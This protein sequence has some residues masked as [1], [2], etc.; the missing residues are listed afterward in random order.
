M[1]DKCL[2]IAIF[3]II[4]NLFLAPLNSELAKIFGYITIITACAYPIIRAFNGRIVKIHVH[5]VCL[6]VLLLISVL[7]SAGSYEAKNTETYIIS[8]ISFIAFYWSISFKPNKESSLDL[9]FF[10]KANIVLCFIYIFHAFGPF[11]EKY[12]VIDSW[13][14]QVFN[15][16]LGNPNA[17]AGY[18]MFS[19]TMLL[20]QL[21]NDVNRLHKIVLAILMGIMVYILF[22]LQSRAV[23]LC[24]IGAILI[25]LIGKERRAMNVLNLVIV[26]APLGMLIVLPALD[27]AGVDFQLL[28][29]Q[30][31]TGRTDVYQKNLDIVLSNPRV[32]IVG[33]FFEFYFQNLHNSSLAIIATLGLS[34]Y[35]IYSVFWYKQIRKIDKEKKDRTQMVA[36]ICLIAYILHSSAET[37]F[38]VGTIPYSVF[39][40]LIVLIAKGEIRNRTTDI[41]D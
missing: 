5:V 26:L 38:M 36:F 35:L 13:G 7:L 12:L 34:G 32:L 22:L 3:S 28:G 23:L 29:K 21:I 15:M 41:V 39:I 24:T 14:N 8:F 31:M 20:I 37:M 27:R 30:L 19:V 25:V 40:V 2:K 11:G 4:I 6:V 16:G 1:H 18:V 9:K 17:V 10:F 33:S